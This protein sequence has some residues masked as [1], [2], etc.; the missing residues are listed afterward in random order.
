MKPAD[1]V[2]AEDEQS[3]LRVEGKFRKNLAHDNALV[4]IFSFCA[5][6]VVLFGSILFNAGSEMIDETEAGVTILF[7]LTVMQSLYYILLAKNKLRL[8]E[9]V[10][11]YGSMD[12]ENIYFTALTALACFAAYVIYS[13]DN[14]SA[15]G[16]DLLAA[17]ILGVLFVMLLVYSGVS[18]RLEKRKK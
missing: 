15:A 5:T 10:E 18:E 4:A 3:I 7:F 1:E 17:A 16:S 13:L 9:S 8:Q 14:N 12:R 6:L 2:Q 11:L